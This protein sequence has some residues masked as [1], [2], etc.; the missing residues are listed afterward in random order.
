MS[1]IPDWMIGFIAFFN[2]TYNY[3]HFLWL[4]AFSKKQYWRGGGQQ[5]NG[6]QSMTA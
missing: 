6:S 1:G 2:I 4:P 5:E 3:N